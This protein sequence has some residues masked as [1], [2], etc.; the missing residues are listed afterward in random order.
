MADAIVAPEEN[1][2][3]L[4]DL[5]ASVNQTQEEIKSTE[6]K[7]AKL[8]TD[9]KEAVEKLQGKLKEF[10]AKAGEFMKLA[11]VNGKRKGGRGH[12]ISQEKKVE[13]ATK[14]LTDA[15]GK[16]AFLD[17]RKAYEKETGAS[18]ANFKQS[19]VKEKTI[20]IKGKGRGMEVSLVPAKK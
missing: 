9:Q 3:E 5:M 13:V 8:K 18:S 11:G 16:M 10:G 14:I 7:L 4:S 17:L 12:G 15:G 6:E 20:R 2:S 1:L 19:L